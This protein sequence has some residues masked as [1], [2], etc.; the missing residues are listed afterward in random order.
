MSAQRVK[1]L[2]KYS[3]EAIVYEDE[4]KRAE[5][6]LKQRVE[7]LGVD[8]TEVSRINRKKKKT[9]SDE[10][11]LKAVVDFEAEYSDTIKAL[12]EYKELEV[13]EM[14]EAGE[15][16]QIV[17]YYEEREDKVIMLWEIRKN[18]VFRVT[19]K[20]KSLKQELSNG[21][22]KITKC[23]EAS[24]LGSELPYDVKALVEERNKIRE[25]INEL[26]KLLPSSD[27]NL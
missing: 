27:Q 14:P 22:Y 24:L 16:D 17:P 12:S 26:E 19:D 2:S 10:K 23:Y 7:S 18:D 15:L 11:I 9:E 20:V 4:K 25:E 8:L 1:I 5:G 13:S 21:D 6:N 3:I